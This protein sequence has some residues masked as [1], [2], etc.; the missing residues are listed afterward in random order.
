MNPPR[1]MGGA[2]KRGEGLRGHDGLARGLGGREDA[3]HPAETGV[4]FEALGER[5]DETGV[6]GVVDG[7]VDVVIG[8]APV[9]RRRRERRE[10]QEAF[11]GARRAGEM[12]GVSSKPSST[13]LQLFSEADDLGTNR[14][15]TDTQS[16]R[17]GDDEI[18]R[19]KA[20]SGEPPDSTRS[21]R[22]FVCTVRA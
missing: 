21:Q 16:N 2:P 6:A 22:G 10:N 19:W 4:G 17:C 13:H 7:D 18:L 20:D 3:E 9:Q 1:T 11:E 14:L 8:L 5:S 15:E 12:S